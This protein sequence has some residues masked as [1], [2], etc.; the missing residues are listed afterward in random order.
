MI[1]QGNGSGHSWQVPGA[2]RGQV[3]QAR[4]EEEREVPRQPPDESDIQQQAPEESRGQEAGLL[5]SAPTRR[6]ASPV[7]PIVVTT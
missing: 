1:F 5:H 7:V 3:R 2:A 4:R 6:V